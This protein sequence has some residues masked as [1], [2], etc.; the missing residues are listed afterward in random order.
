MIMLL[1][2]DVDSLCILLPFH[3]FYMHRVR[4]AHFDSRHWTA[5]FENINV[6]SHLQA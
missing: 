3:N 2:Y 6:Y 1:L 5:K 4:L